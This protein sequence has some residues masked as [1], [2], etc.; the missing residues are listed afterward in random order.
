MVYPF[1]S[2]YSYIG[3]HKFVIWEAHRFDEK[4]DFSMYAPGEIIDIYDGKLK[5]RTVDGS[6]IVDKCESN[7]TPRGGD[8]FEKDAV[9]RNKKFNAWKESV[10]AV[11]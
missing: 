7:L 1:P 11:Y 6:L 8:V 2:S 4:I 5:V 10:C 3:K 9:N